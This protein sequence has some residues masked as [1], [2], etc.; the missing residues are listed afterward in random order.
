M[1]DG[2]PRAWRRIGR[3]DYLNTDNR[4]GYRKLQ[5]EGMAKDSCHFFLY[6]E[7]DRE[8]RLVIVRKRTRMAFISS[9]AISISAAMIL[10]FN[11]SK[12]FKSQRH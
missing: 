8:A 2:L 11:I 12:P 3:K 5:K 4:E 9:T 6:A 1:V 10:F 7:A